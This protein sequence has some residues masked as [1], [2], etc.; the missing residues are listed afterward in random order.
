MTLLVKN[1]E[2]FKAAASEI[3]QSLGN[4]KIISLRGKMGAGKTTMISA[5]CEKWKV[6]DSVNSPT[7]SI[8]NEYITVD[9]ETIYHFDFY[10]I[11]KL[12]EALEIGVVEYFESG[13]ICLLEWAENIAELLPD[14]IL[15]IDIEEIENGYRKIHITPNSI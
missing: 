8:V 13:N 3:I 1:L 9:D 11:T 5:M 4:H 2:E 12:R 6:I 10:R 7:F 15:N 14:H